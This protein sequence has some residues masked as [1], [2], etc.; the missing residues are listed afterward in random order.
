LD[1]SSVT[2]AADSI[3]TFNPSA[4]AQG[5]H[6]LEVV[7]T[8][9]V[10]STSSTNS[11]QVIPVVTPKV[12]LSASDTIINSGSSTVTITANAVSGGGSAPQYSFA[13]DRAFTNVLQQN[14]GNNSISIQPSTLKA[15]G[16]WIYVQMK[17]SDTCYTTQTV[18]D[19]IHL[20]LNTAIGLVGNQHLSKSL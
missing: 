4:L 3:L 6:Q 14:S 15:G 13:S 11:F 8:N 20:L 7:Y 1:T 5:N 9:S 10:G 18:I 2:I 19:S 16:N 17:T 12:Q